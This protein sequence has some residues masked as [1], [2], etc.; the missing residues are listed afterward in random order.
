[1][2]SSLLDLLL[3]LSSCFLL[4][5]LCPLQGLHFGLL[6]PFLLN[7]LLLIRLA[8][9]LISDPLLLFIDDFVF[10]WLLSRC[11]LVFAFVTSCNKLSGFGVTEGLFLERKVLKNV[12]LG[13]LPLNHLLLGLRDLSAVLV[14]S[15]YYMNRFGP[16]RIA[17]FVR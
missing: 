4:L 14:R 6:I 2:N 8:F 7:L 12:F 9:L 1:M 15:H 16:W 13:Q 10:L 5:L 11:L 17:L 3:F